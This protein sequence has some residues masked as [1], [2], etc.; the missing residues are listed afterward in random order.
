MIGCESHLGFFIRQRHWVIFSL[1][2]S[3]GF[4]KA[5]LLQWEYQL[6]NER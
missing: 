5:S 3:I 2:D 1:R 4:L 6:A